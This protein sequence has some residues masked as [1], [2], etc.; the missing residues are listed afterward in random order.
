MS[1]PKSVK[2]ITIKEIIGLTGVATDEVKAHMLD[3]AKQGGSAAELAAIAGEVQGY[4]AKASQYGE[5][6]FLTGNFVSLNRQTGEILESNK[7]YLP[8]DTT[9][10]VMAEY[11]NRTESTDLVSIKLIIRVIL[12]KASSTGYSYV[13]KPIE[14]PELINKKAKLVALLSNLP[15]LPQLPAPEAKPH[16][17]SK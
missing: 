3:L 1:E 7:L 12:D 15:A 4:G 5:S 13:C 8:K 2:K 14:T 9:E 16:A 10:N 6:F 17:K 11:K